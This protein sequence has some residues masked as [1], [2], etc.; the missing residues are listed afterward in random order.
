M[1]VINYTIF[2]RSF[3]TQNDVLWWHVVYGFSSYGLPFFSL[4][5][6]KVE[7][8]VS[9]RCVP[10]TDRRRNC[11]P[12]TDNLEVNDPTP[13]QDSGCL[14]SS[15]LL[16]HSPF[17]LYFPSFLFPS[18][19]PPYAFSGTI[20]WFRLSHRGLIF[21]VMVPLVR[22]Y[23]KVRG[24]KFKRLTD[25]RRGGFRVEKSRVRRGTV[26]NWID[27]LSVG[28]G[29]FFT[30]NIRTFTTLEIQSISGLY[31]LFLPVAH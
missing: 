12:K 27:I 3:W 6:G 5:S 23:C 10:P 19:L 16:L 9:P 15:L 8:T 7:Y 4:T 20:P 30:E 13:P 25:R 17:F 26:T 22:F 2:N 29:S 11:K 24:P 21:T 31:G 1:C 14:Y 18:C 28:S